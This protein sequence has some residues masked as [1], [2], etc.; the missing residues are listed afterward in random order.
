MAVFAY[1]GA[2]AVAFALSTVAVD[3]VLVVVV[4]G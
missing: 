4:D 1:E 3:S 2:A